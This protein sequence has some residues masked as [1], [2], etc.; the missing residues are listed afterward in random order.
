MYNLYSLL[1]LFFVFIVVRFDKKNM[2]ILSLWK[3][4]FSIWQSDLIKNSKL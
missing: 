4:S 1:F 3:F 2:A